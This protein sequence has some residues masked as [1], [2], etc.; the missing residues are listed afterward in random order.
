MVQMKTKMCA[1]VLAASLL[2]ST[3]MIGAADH[4]KTTPAMAAESQEQF[5]VSLR[6]AIAA[7][8][9]RPM[10]SGS[11]QTARASQDQIS[12]QESRPRIT[13]SCSCG[14]PSW[15]KYSLIGVAAAGGGY[16]LSQAV[17]GHGRG[18]DRGRR[19]NDAD[20]MNR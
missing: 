17:G 20:G 15:L 3:T 19:M 14:I 9:T 7:I 1:V 18:D 5:H 11:I 4:G 6:Q 8:A 2:S 16:A 10:A 13:Q 12:S